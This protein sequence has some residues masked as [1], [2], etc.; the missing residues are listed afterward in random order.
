MSTSNFDLSQF[1]ARRNSNYNISPEGNGDDQSSPIE[2]IEDND[3]DE[4]ATQTV[5]D[6]KEAEICGFLFS[7]SKDETGEY[8]PVRMGSNLIG[9]SNDDNISLKQAT[10]TANHAKLIV[11]RANGKL[12]MKITPK[13]IVQVNGLEINGET[14][15]HD[16]D[17]LTIG[18]AYQL[19]L[20]F[21]DR[22]KYGLEKAKNFEEA[23]TS[24]ADQDA[25]ETMPS[26]E[27]EGTVFLQ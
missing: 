3:C 16:R 13:G 17:I 23:D 8:W 1:Y 9:S 18:N 10:V 25:T 12:A 15:C 20:L 7:V 22:E 27:E 19:L 26:A 11:E 5:D 4:G 24:A 21:A 2:I 14:I 6:E